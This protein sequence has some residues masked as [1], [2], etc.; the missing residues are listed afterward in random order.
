MTSITYTATRGLISGHSVGTPY[1][2]DLGCQQI[3]PSGAVTKE[4]QTSLSGRRESL[5][6]YRESL[7]DVTSR[8]LAGNALLQLREFL[9]SCEADEPFTWDAYGTIGTPDDPVTAT[10]EGG[11]FSEQRFQP[12]G[13]GGGNDYF[14]INFRVR[15]V[16]A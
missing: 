4:S 6:F 3:D 16:E 9:K 1:S 13:Q 14:V 2:F 11:Q 7:Y 12:R 5:R 15:V 8:P 10:I